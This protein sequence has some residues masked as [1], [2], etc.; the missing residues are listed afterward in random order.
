MAPFPFLVFGVPALD[1]GVLAADFGV[2]ALDFGVLT[3]DLPNFFFGFGVKGDFSDS[4]L[5]ELSLTLALD[6]FFFFFCFGLLGAF[7]PDSELYINLALDLT[8]FFCFGVIAAFSPDSE[9]E[10]SP[11]V[12]SRYQ[13]GMVTR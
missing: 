11:I 6:F 2:L 5:S 7:S 12:A 13:Y 9:S 10:L 8:N 1:F 4:E 3:A